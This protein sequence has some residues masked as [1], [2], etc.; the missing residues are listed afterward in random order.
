MSPTITI[1]TI[2]FKTALKQYLEVTKKTLP[3]VMNQKALY[4][5]KGAY[6]ETP[7]ADKSKIMKLFGVGPK[8]KGVKTKYDYSKM[9]TSAENIYLWR[10][11]Q[12]NKDIP[13]DYK[14]RALKMVQNRIKAVGSLR[15]G[16][17]KAISI[18]AGAVNEMVV[19]QGPPIKTPSTAKPATPGFNPT[20]TFTY[21]TVIERGG[22]KIIDP[23]C[24]QALQS[25]FDKEAKSM[26]E[27][28]ARR[29]QSD[30]NQFTAK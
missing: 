23:R 26:T 4:I 21:R 12:A 14:K 25:A 5:A 7:V 16:W 20:S 29:M 9:N 8:V 15:S 1:D 30:A 27:Y 6:E 28:L 3:D 17:K 22:Q 19:A 13:A 11:K 2:Q 10:L 18:L 24:F